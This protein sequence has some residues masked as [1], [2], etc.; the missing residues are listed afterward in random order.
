MM[1]GLRTDGRIL[2]D[3][4]EFW[5][6]FASQLT[7]NWMKTSKKKSQQLSAQR[8]MSSASVAGIN[9]SLHIRL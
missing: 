7:S 8:N 6:L 3:F 2:P 5:P 9:Q 1:K 4:Q